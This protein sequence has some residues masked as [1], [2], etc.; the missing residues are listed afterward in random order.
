[1]LADD[2]SA[3]IPTGGTDISQDD[4]AVGHRAMGVITTSLETSGRFQSR[5]F[6]SWL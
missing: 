5:K 6:T 1:M 4:E 3:F 2:C